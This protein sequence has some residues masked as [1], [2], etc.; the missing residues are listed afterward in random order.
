MGYQIVFRS[1]NIYGPYESRI[2][3]D[4]GMTRVNGPHQGGW[5]ETQTGE[6]W[7]IHFQEYLPYGRIVHLQPVRWVD[8]WPVMGEDPDGDGKGQPV[9][10][11]RKPDVGRTYPI[12]VP[13]TSD[14]FDSA[15]LGLQWQWFA[16][17]VDDW[18][19][20]S[21]RPGFMRMAA[22]AMDKPVPLS[23]RPNLLLQK[24]PAEQFMLTTRID[25]THLED[26]DRTGLVIP[27]RATAALE[28]EKTS[29]GMKIIRT[30]SDARQKPGPGPSPDDREEDTAVATG[31]IIFLRVKVATHGVCTFSYSS[32][33]VKFNDLGRWFTAVNDHWIEAKVGLFC[34][35]PVGRP[36]TGQV[37][38]DW[39]R[40]A[41]VLIQ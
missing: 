5:V 16:N 11:H 39:F 21:D 33:G 1:K 38:V 14:E 37:D 35:A 6:G 2:V 29:K 28:V 7:F 12:G 20:L 10:V 30:T 26:G 32:D 40:F 24:F 27:G 36:S 19:T 3:L 8:D 22:V 34:N 17:F 4:R 13:Q 41:P 31:P 23:D 15:K 18:V 25:V 9:L